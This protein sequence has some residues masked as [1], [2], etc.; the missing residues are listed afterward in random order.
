M[1]RPG[2]VSVFTDAIQKLRELPCPPGRNARAL[3]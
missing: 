2:N 3:G 1:D